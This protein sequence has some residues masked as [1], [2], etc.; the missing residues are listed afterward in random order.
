MGR[1]RVWG[2]GGG[3]KKAGTETSFLG[4]GGS[5]ATATGAS[6][7]FAPIIPQPQAIKPTMTTAA[8]SDNIDL[9]LPAN[10]IRLLPI[11]SLSYQN[12]CSLYSHPF[13]KY[14]ILK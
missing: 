3:A 9:P 12:L 14:I 7:C 5:G 13:N 6:S 8:I 4:I 11:N 1:D 2:E 10:S